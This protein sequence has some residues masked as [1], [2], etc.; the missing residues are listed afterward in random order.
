LEISGNKDLG[1]I[2]VPTRNRV[3]GENGA[4]VSTGKKASLLKVSGDYYIL[5][6]A[7]ASRRTARVLARGERFAVFE[8]TGDI[9]ESPVEALGFFYR[10]TRHLSRF[11]ISI[12]GE[13][14]HFLNSYVSDDNTEVRAN[15]T[16]PDFRGSDDSIVLP[17]DTIQIRR[18]W[19]LAGA[20]LVQQIA[21]RNFAASTVRIRLEFGIGADFEDM[22]EVR[23][24]ARKQ[25]GETQPAKIG[26][27]WVKF[28]YNGV[29]AVKRSTTITFS[30]KPAELTEA[31]ASFDLALK[32]DASMEMEVRVEARHDQPASNGRI[33]VAR[34]FDSALK[35]RRAEV[36]EITSEFTRIT[37]SNQYTNSL[38]ER[39]LGDLSALTTVAERGHYIMAG[40]PW[41]A[42]LFGR[43]SILTAFSVL[44]F[45]PQLAAGILRTLASLQ[46]VEVNDARDEQPGKII[47]EM[48][49]CEMANTSEVPFGRYY[50][51]IDSTPLFLWLLG[52]YVT[53]TGDL[54]IA[55]ELWPNVERARG[56]IADYGDRD[57]DGYIEY[58]R[59]TPRG[60]AN[61]GWKDSLDAI[62]HA[63]G[64]LAKP[65]IAL[66]EV[67]GYV[68]AAYTSLAE[69]AGRLDRIHIRDLLREKAEALKS[70]F[71]HDFW[72]K[73]EGMLALALDG[74]K[75]PC[76]VMASNGAH[77]L[78]A[79]LLSGKR[80]AVL[81]Q[82]LLADDMFSGWGIRTLSDRERRFNPMSYHNGSVW[83][84]DNAMAAW[85]LSC[86]GKTEGAVKI[87]TGLF[88]GAAGL[89]NESLPE[90]FCGF[91]REPNLGPVPY[92]V[93]CHPQAWSAA[94]VFLL[95]Q[96]ILGMQVYGAERRLVLRAPVIPEW[97]E[98]VKFD[99]LRV[100]KSKL[101]FI[102]RRGRNGASI[103]VLEKQG[104]ASVE[105]HK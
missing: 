72:L 93:A 99:N 84:H 79:G 46:G 53:A 90:L 25:R 68:Y 60:L 81:S 103:E 51:S 21:I 38:L 6:S 30:K 98:W 73:Q 75:N 66:A 27:N 76:R 80:A 83:P 88:D 34:S 101:S 63:D 104:Q 10:D 87:M 65:P 22:F 3:D 4:G 42:T 61:Q 16:N 64:T 92:P 97:L 44:P 102:A 32:R 82:R 28:F 49:A 56:W 11:E 54:K 8:A 52:R 45:F 89:N 85:G 58:E 77:C 26:G 17:R 69:I 18:S 74:S 1:V 31:H 37:T 59:E 24:I 50:G 62:S 94:S 40:I 9:L 20:N 12:G 43:D 47:H 67:Q 78:A 41:F 91:A 55:R 29:D 105:V 48:R 57:A 39:S 36:E 2:T 86:I 100:G 23:G 71:E 13:V 15:L 5:A 95:L 19:V 14:P 96:S 7:M 33:V 35:H 70:R